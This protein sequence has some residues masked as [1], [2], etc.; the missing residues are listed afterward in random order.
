MV[1]R[2]RPE[3]RFLFEGLPLPRLPATKKV[4]PCRF[5]PE[6]VDETAAPANV[7]PESRIEETH[8]FNLNGA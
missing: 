7:K 2:W 1:I 5:F 3:S 6:W 8:I 4:L